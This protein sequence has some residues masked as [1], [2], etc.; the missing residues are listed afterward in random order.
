MMPVIGILDWNGEREIYKCWLNNV[1]IANVW[2]FPGISVVKNCLS[3]QETQSPSLGWEDPLEKQ[4]ATHSSTLAWVIPWTEKPGGLQSMGSQKSRTWLRKKTTP[5]A[6][7]WYAGLKCEWKNEEEKIPIKE[8]S[9]E[10]CGSLS[11]EMD[12]IIDKA[13]KNKRWFG[14]EAG[15]KRIGNSVGTDLVP[16]IHRQPGSSLRAF[17]VLEEHRGQGWLQSRSFSGLCI[18]T[19]LIRWVQFRSV[20]QLC[21]TLCEPMNHSTPAFPFL[22]CLLELAQIHVHWVGDA[23]QPSHPVLPPSPAAFNISQNQGLFQ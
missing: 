18:V 12:M 3:M 16:G 19:K 14:F 21:L 6:N 17:L 5:P 10:K 15:S 8:T 2:G 7:V 4:M 23:I 9:K 1:G 13:R 11:N 22:H 20:A